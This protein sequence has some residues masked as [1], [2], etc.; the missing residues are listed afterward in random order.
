MPNDA[1]PSPLTPE[2]Q[3]DLIEPGLGTPPVVHTQPQSI[4]ETRARFL[5]VERG[6]IGRT[7]STKFE[8]NSSSQF[9][10]WVTSRQDVSGVIQIGNIIAALSDDLSEMTFASVT[11][12][13]SY[14]D[15]E[16]FIA[17]F[18][19]H[20][21]GE[22]DVRVPTD[23]SE[24]VVVTC[25]VMRNLSLTTKPIGRSSVYFP[26][27][28]G[29]QF[30]YG[31]VD[32][33]GE[34]IFAGAAIPLGLFENG[35]GTTA[36][37]SV[38][39]HFVV[40]PEGAHLN[41]SGI[42]GLASKTSAVQFALKSVLTFSEK[43]LAVVMFNVK[44]RDLL[45]I[46]QP[47]PRFVLDDDLVSWSLRAYQTLNIPREPFA[48]ATFFAPSDPEDP[49]STQSLRRLP[50][51]TFEWSLDMI[52]R[53]IPSLFSSLD[54]DD[55]MEGAWFVVQDEI[56]RDQILTYAQMLTWL[57]DMITR[58]QRQ[59]QMYLRAS[60]IATWQ[61]LR[62]HLKR[63]PH[64]FR[65]LIAT[66]GEGTD[67]PWGAIEDKSVYVIDIQMLSDQGQKLV[68]G[69]SIRALRR[70][71][72]NEETTLDGIIVFV[73]ELNKFAPSG[74]LRSPLKSHLVD[75]TARGRSLGLILFGAEQF[76]SS[77]EKEIVENCS[78]HLTGRTE[79]NEL[80]SPNYAALSNEM[81]T[82]L[83]MLPQG[84][85]LIRFP[86][87][88]QPIYLKFPLPPCCSGDQFQPS[89]T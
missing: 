33:G 12:M 22:A 83:T 5:N 54:W 85:L 66:A 80:R 71:L 23:I 56:E 58:G 7:V 68:F 31:L 57:D 82:K 16:S 26:S 36:P 78:T 38:D 48:N 74:H 37:I 47:N 69:R 4:P 43:R 53:D 59:N 39:E 30:S 88:A 67:I 84:Q 63:F 64:S 1:K 35:D 86:K 21:F 27:T 2:T 6:S 75:I 11:E 13:R 28:L 46:D 40:G 72:E 60:H 24:V 61:K 9:N 45:Y 32:E 50:T 52:Y 18:L 15:V 49:N 81:K 44:S 14:S 41:V 51:S 65:G 76:A 55:K 8:P 17:D 25:A 89:E 87:F 3:S 70:L 34:E 19:S 29:I 73:D 77:V 42:S 62:S 79:T 20:N 10:F